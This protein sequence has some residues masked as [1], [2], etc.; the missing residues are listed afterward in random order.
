MGEVRITPV[1]LAHS[2]NPAG[3]GSSGASMCWEVP[4]IQARP[5]IVG[6][7]ASKSPTFVLAIGRPMKCVPMSDSFISSSPIDICPLATS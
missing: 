2:K 4:V 7:M 3:K 5:V 6:M 1:R